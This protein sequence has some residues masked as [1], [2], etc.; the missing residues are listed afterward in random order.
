DD[1]IVGRPAIATSGTKAL[2]C[3]PK[4]L[5]RPPEQGV[6]CAWIDGISG[7][8]Y[9]RDRI[10]I[11]SDPANNVYMNQPSLA[12]LGT[13]RFA[14]QVI[15]STGPQDKKAHRKGVSRTHL[16]VLE[17]SDTDGPGAAGVKAS[18]SGVGVFQTHTAIISGK[19]GEKGERH[20]GLFEAPITGGG[21]P[22]LSFLGYDAG[23]Q[24]WRPLDERD[25]WIVGPGS[26]D[27]GNLANQYGANPSTHGRDLIR[28]IGD[29]P[30][31]GA[32]LKGGWMSQVKSFFVLPYAGRQSVGQK[33]ALFLSFVP[34][35]TLPLPP[36]PRPQPEPEPKPNPGDTSPGDTG[37]SACG[38]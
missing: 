27:S 4:G 15:E 21:V 7:E 26:G 2:I 9:F 5:N 16:Y 37:S 13:G 34:G 11:F 25:Q 14:L 1:A 31:P 8:A 28:G 32:G 30:N 17:P 12:P 24:K 23:G 36:D 20:V 3:A 19:Y 10:V 18:V 38:V 6:A 33:N 35:E 22:V 29:V